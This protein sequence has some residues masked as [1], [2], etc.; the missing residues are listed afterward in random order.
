MCLNP[1]F[2]IKITFSNLSY[3]NSMRYSILVDI[4]QAKLIF[5]RIIWSKRAKNVKKNTFLRKK[6]VFKTN[7]WQ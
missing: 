5:K 3:R 7:F 2:G 6:C 4:I 1:F